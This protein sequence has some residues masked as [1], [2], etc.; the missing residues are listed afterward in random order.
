MINYHIVITNQTKVSCDPINCIT[1]LE[2]S[3][4]SYKHGS[5]PPYSKDNLKSN[6]NNRQIRNSKLPYSF[7]NESRFESERT[8]SNS[9]KKKIV[10]LN[11]NDY[12][13]IENAKYSWRK[14]LSLNSQNETDIHLSDFKFNDE[15]L[16]P[17]WTNAKRE[18]VYTL[19]SFIF[20]F[21]KDYDLPNFIRRYMK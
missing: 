10:K 21:S 13:Q 15:T 9:H 18:L 3:I 14:D 11:F 12:T 5:P 8:A 2:S 6:K 16:I 1:F 19:M 7:N 17:S 4:K 20:S